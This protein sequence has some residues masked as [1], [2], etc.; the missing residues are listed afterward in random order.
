MAGVGGGD[1][2]TGGQAGEGPRISQAVRPF[3]F[4]LG[5]GEP[6]KDSD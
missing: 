3:G 1:R 2:C 4:D 6:L 5:N